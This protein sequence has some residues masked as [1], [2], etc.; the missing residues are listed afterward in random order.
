MH[1]FLRGD[2]RSCVLIIFCLEGKCAGQP[3]GQPLLST[4]RTLLHVQCCLAAANFSLDSYSFHIMTPSSPSP[5]DDVDE[6]MD[7]YA[8]KA[9][10]ETFLMSKVKML[11][12]F[13]AGNDRV[14]KEAI[15]NKLRAVR[16]DFTS[17][18]S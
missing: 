8:S 10:V 3:A 1:P 18:L 14:D 9:E 16:L 15:K 4:A 5:E 2:W 13:L 7:G 11:D 17:P 12:S 6:D